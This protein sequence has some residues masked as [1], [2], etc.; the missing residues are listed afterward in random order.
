MT[1]NGKHLAVMVRSPRPE[2]VRTTSLVTGERRLAGNGIFLIELPHQGAG[3]HN[4][5]SE[6]SSAAF[7]AALC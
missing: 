7:T 5:L 4:V 1:T 6:L 2:I 3:T